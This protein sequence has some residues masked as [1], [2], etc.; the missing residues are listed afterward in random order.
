RRSSDLSIGVGSYLVDGDQ[1]TISGILGNG[2]A[3]G[4]YSVSNVTANTFDLGVDEVQML[5]LTGAPTGGTFTLEYQ[6]P[7]NEVQR[8]EMAGLPMDGHFALGFRPPVGGTEFTEPI[9]YDATAAEVQAALEGPAVPTID[10]GDVLV[11]GGPLAGMNEVQE[12]EITGAPV[13]GDVFTLTYLHPATVLPGNIDDVQTSFTV[14]NAAEFIGPYGD[15][16]DVPFSIRLDD[17][18]M[19]VSNVTGNVLT[20]S[21]GDNATA[22]APHT[23]GTKVR[24]IQRTLPIEVNAPAYRAENEVQRMQLSAFPEDQFRLSFLHPDTQ[25]G[26]LSA[27]IND[28]ATTVIVPVEDFNVMTDAFGA[29]LPTG[30]L[31]E[32]QQ[33]NVRIDDEEMRV[34][35]VDTSTA[36][37]TLTVVREFNGTSLATHN[38]PAEIHYIETTELL[39]YL[40]TAD[41]SRNDVQSITMNG[42]PD[43]GTFTL[44]FQHPATE[45]TTLDGPIDNLLTTTIIPVDD[46]TE[47]TD[48]FGNTLVGAEPF[49]IIIDR[50]TA[51]EEMM[52]VIA[53]N[54]VANT[55]EV[56]RAVNGTTAA[57]HLDGIQVFEVQTTRPIA[58]DAP[59][60]DT[61]NEVQRIALTNGAD[62]GSFTLTLLHPEAIPADMHGRNE[63]QQIAMSGNPDGGQFAL[64]FESPAAANSTLAV[65]ILAPGPASIEVADGSQFTTLTPFPVRI[66]DEIFTVTNVSVDT[67]T[68]TPGDL[69]SSPATHALG[70]SV[71]EMVTTVQLNHDAT[72]AEV[73][74]ALENL[75]AVGFGNVIATLGPLPGTPVDVEFVGVLAAQPIGVL[76]SDSRLLTEL[77]VHTDENADITTSQEGMSGADAGETVIYVADVDQMLDGNGVVVP[78]GVLAA[79]DQFRIRIDDEEMLV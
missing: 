12:I 8:I 28:Q 32:G 13:G 16:L 68:V 1:V 66:G 63:I 31:P 46:V 79:P 2:A 25:P 67:L 18:E 60:D 52:R 61:A 33:F 44:T 9:E 53:V 51:D 20:V 10:P 22:P 62:G 30:I 69:G 41:D 15:P 21:R 74:T 49:N 40:A 17:E 70:A 26:L 73:Q 75:V 76:H 77:A 42:D 34:I 43:G 72:A 38:A 54:D 48:G 14:N 7:T 65:E 35:S 19:V 11:T 59:A 58:F 27:Q 45:P 57:P 5:E 24:E 6:Q 3:N 39:S 36:T 56:V 23:L 29:A 64:S 47:M 4:V 71:V 55:L 50:G 78:D 37:H